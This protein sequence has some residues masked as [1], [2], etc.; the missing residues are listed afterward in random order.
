M[1]NSDTALIETGIKAGETDMFNEDEIWSRSSSDKPDIGRALA[2]VIRTLDRTLPPS[3]KLVALSL[4]S[5]SEPQFRILE[6][7][8]RGGLFLLDCDPCPLGVVRER[9][10]RQFI[11]GVKTIRADYNRA[12]LDPRDASNFRKKRLGGKRMDLV[13]LHHSLYYSEPEQWEQLF[14]NLYRIILARRGAIHAVLMSSRSRDRHSTTWLYNHFAGK[15][16]GCRNDQDLL[17]LGDQLRRKPGFKTARI[18]SRTHKIRF[19]VDDFGKFMAVVWMILLSPNVHVY[20]RRQKEEITEY[21]YRVFWSKKQP[22]L[23][24]QDHLVVYRGRP[25]L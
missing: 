1:K 8:C 10:R 16:F 12:L 2:A 14:A 23:Q 6:A 17:K 13:T 11:G 4:G 18:I 20:N 9:C 24:Y 7:A 19:R 5:G 15:Y 3:R 25:G 21:I 22:L